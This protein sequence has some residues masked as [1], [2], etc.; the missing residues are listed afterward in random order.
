VRLDGSEWLGSCSGQDQFS[1]LSYALSISQTDATD[2]ASVFDYHATVVHEESHWVRFHGTTIGA[3]LALIQ[4]AQQLTAAQF[5]GLSLAEKGRLWRQRDNG[6]PIFTFPVLGTAGSDDFKLFRQLW[7][8]MKIGYKALLDSSSL[9]GIQWDRRAAIESALTDAFIFM[10]SVYDSSLSS[11]SPASDPRT[12]I[13]ICGSMYFLQVGRRKQRLT[14]RS[15]FECAATLDQLLGILGSAS[16]ARQATLVGVER[17][18]HTLSEPQYGEPV[19]TFREIIGGVE[20]SSLVEHSS[21][22]LA[23]IDF[24]LNP[25]LPPA[26]SSPLDMRGRRWEELYPPARFTA[27]CGALASG[28]IAILNLECSD[29]DLREFT[30]AV[31]EATGMLDPFSYSGPMCTTAGDGSVRYSDVK[32]RDQYLFYLAE[33]Q[34]R[35]WALRLSEP[36]AVMLYGQNLSL[37]ASGRAELV[38]DTGVGWFRAPFHLSRSDTFAYT[39]PP[40]PDVSLRYLS[41]LAVHITLNNAMTQVSGLRKDQIP[42]GGLPEYFWKQVRRVSSEMLDYEF[43]P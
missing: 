18:L 40:G 36:S 31:A 2:L 28:D 34:R 25:P 19:L 15:L 5:S 4:Y 29:D 32:N 42:Q 1:L 16:Y 6:Q 37:R 13:Q 43:W 7:L 38:F 17:V 26:I 41:S 12:A 33:T 30:R 20:L 11:D 22:I 10:P 35:L 14:T 21:T 27:A 23:L 39:D 3:A 9:D 8:D 24:S